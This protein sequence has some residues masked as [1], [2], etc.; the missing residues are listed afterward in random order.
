MEASA[1]YVIGTITPDAKTTCPSVL[2]DSLAVNARSVV[3]KTIAV[4]RRRR[5]VTQARARSARCLRTKAVALTL[6]FAQTLVMGK[7]SASAARWTGNA[8]LKSVS[9]SMA[10]VGHVILLIT[11]GVR[12]THRSA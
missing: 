9:V 5:F 11:A 7:L 8:P 1:K 6:L 3:I 12:K 4:T 2:M 10:A